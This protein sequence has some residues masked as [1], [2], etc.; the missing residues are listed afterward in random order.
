MEE[1]N[2]DYLFTVKSNQKSVLSDI[3]RLNLTQKPCEFK[4]VD[5]EHERIETRKIWTSTALNDYLDFPY[6][7]QVF[8]VERYVYY[9][10]SQKSSREFAYGVTS[11]PTNQANPERLLS[12]DRKHWTIENQLHYVRDMVY[13]E[14]RSQIKTGNGPQVMASLKNLAL[15]ILRL[16]NYKI[17]KTVRDLADLTHLALRLLGI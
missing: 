11:L 14:D 8:V 9:K 17:T 15:N 4:T 2:A 5:T 3:A 7:Q 16:G 13:D 6:V 10:K 1:K 12:L